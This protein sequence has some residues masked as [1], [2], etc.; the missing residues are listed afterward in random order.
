[1]FR[2][3]KSLSRDGGKFAVD[4]SSDATVAVIDPSGTVFE[5]LVRACVGIPM[6]RLS[7][8]IPTNGWRPVLAVFAVYGPQD[9]KR[10]PAVVRA[11]PTVVVAVA[12]DA[13]HAERARLEGAFGLLHTSLPDTALRRAI[14]GA[15]RGE[16]AYSRAALGEHIKAELAV[17]NGRDPAKL[18]PRQR[19]IV[20]LIA[21]GNSDREIGSKLGITTSTAQK[22]VHELLRRLDVPNRAAAVAAMLAPR[23]LESRP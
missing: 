19:E 21:R 6:R 12:D 1:M 17:S 18:T 2:E 3:G 13:S 23:S 8:R 14:V 4:A 10:L 11:L 20:R 22:H 16:P 15:L 7:R 9:W 5:T